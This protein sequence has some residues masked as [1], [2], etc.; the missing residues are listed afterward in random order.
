[1]P[2]VPGAARVERLRA[3]PLFEGLEDRALD[4]IAASLTEFE[5]PAGQILLQPGMAGAGMF[6]VEEG[7][8]LVER[9]GRPD[10]ELGP[11]Q[12][13]GE[14][15]LLSDRGARVARVRTRVQSILLALSREEFDRILVEEPLIAVAMLRTVADRM[16]RD[17]E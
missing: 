9:P 12:F 3:I 8:V 14:L 15:A 1:M 11:G 5:A 6:V 16:A 17:A 7:G 10:V 4:R 2:S 13:V